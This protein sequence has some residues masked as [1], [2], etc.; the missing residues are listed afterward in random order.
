LNWSW[1]LLLGILAVTAAPKFIDL[2]GD[3]KGATLQGVKAAIE[4]ANAGVHAKS[5]I[6]GNNQVLKASTPTILLNGATVE[7]GSGWALA[8]ID[9]ANDMLDISAAD[10]DR[11]VGTNNLVISPKL[12]TAKNL[13]DAITAACYVQYIESTD[14]NTKP[15]ITAVI[16]GC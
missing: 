6:K 7:I 12:D 2:Q 16:T 9:N 15:A 5:L 4:T 10:F 11:I 14:S 13:A 1:S 8:T 3:A